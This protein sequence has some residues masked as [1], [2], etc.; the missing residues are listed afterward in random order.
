MSQPSRVRTNVVANLAG[1]A[2]QA[3]LGLLLP[4]LFA[5]WMGLE[6]YGLV[7]FFT[8]LTSLLSLFDLG[9]GMTL[10][11]EV[12][13]LSARPG[14]G[15]A[16]R[17]VADLT[18]TFELIY[19]AMGASFALAVFALAPWLSRHAIN[20]ST[21]PEAEAAWAIR[22][23]GVALGAQLGQTAYTGVLLG[24]QRQA[25]LNAF[26]VATATAKHGTAALLLYS[27]PG[28]AVPYFAG[29][30]GAALAGAAALAYAV[31]RSTGAAGGAS[32]RIEIVRRNAR[33]AA[34]VWL[35]YPLSFLLTQADKFVVGKMLPLEEFGHYA[36][37]LTAGSA[38]YFL[39]GPIFSAVLPRFTQL[40]EA[41][42]RAGLTQLFRKASQALVVLVVPAAATLVA[43]R[44]PL[45]ALWSRS[46]ATAAHI[47]PAF[48]LRAAATAV[49]CAL[50]APYLLSLATG[51]SRFALAINGATVLVLL[52]LEVV[53]VARAGIEGAALGWLVAISFAFVAWHLVVRRRGWL[54]DALAP[55]LWHG[56]VRPAA[57]S[58]L[59]VWLARRFGPL[60]AGKP[61]TLAL[62]AL[63]GALAL[64]A[65]ALASRD[66]APLLAAGAGRAWA[67]LRP[68]A[69]R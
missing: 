15:E 19:W 62:A 23:M 30:A 10:S 46:E 66:L 65:G 8:S 68:A 48:A 6:A 59:V 38:A 11:R 34:G 7:G 27:A 50:H 58:L 28:S 67:R 45:L 32:F 3:A 44:M 18:R 24:A 49:H 13:R 55:T 4:P 29:H 35:M 64:A 1:S 57:A 56:L 53:L 26:Q 37:A 43:Y 39:G 51:T 47:A 5:R 42:D 33:Y 52:P 12:A 14:D 31:R 25:L 20:R 9:L 60:P 22:L 61:Q 41:G 17:E 36:L 21:L 69:R 54:D 63:V 2:W 16:R 40:F